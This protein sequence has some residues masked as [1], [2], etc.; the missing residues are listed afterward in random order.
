MIV[1]VEAAKAIEIV[2]I[3]LLQDVAHMALRHDLRRLREHLGGRLGVQ[4]LAGDRQLAGRLLRLANHLGD[5][6]RLIIAQASRLA[7]NL[8]FR[9]TIV[10]CA[11]CD[12]ASLLWLFPQHASL[13]T[14]PATG[15]A[16]PE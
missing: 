12:R 8:P 5:V 13:D 14:L 2:A 10:I 16:L 3:E 7:K 11:G 1:F 6:L 4:V 9:L 15:D